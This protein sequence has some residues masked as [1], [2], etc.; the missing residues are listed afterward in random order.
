MGAVFR[1]PPGNDR[2]FA[3]YHSV[4]PVRIPPDVVW[5]RSS[6]GQKGSF[7]TGPCRNTVHL[8]RVLS[9]VLSQPHSLSDRYL[10]QPSGCGPR[11]FAPL[12]GLALGQERPGTLWQASL[13][14][15]P[16]LLRCGRWFSC[17]GSIDYGPSESAAIPFARGSNCRA[18]SLL[19]FSEVPVA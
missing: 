9:G 17:A 3:Q 5:A 11:R 15:L 8:G 19:C 6:L 1:T 14:L 7:S 2:R 12:V 16:A 13:L 10:H 4:C 18:N